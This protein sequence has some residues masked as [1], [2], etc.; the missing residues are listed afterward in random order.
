LKWFLEGNDTFTVEGEEIILSAGAVVSPQI[1]M[2]SGVG[3][4]NHLSHHGINTIKDSP[5]VGQNLADHPMVYV[6][7]KTK[8]EVDLDA[9][10]PRIQLT[11]RYTADGSDLDNDM[12]VYMMAVASDRPERGG[13]R[14]EPIGIQTNLCINLAK[15]KGE[16]KLNSNDYRDQPYLDYNYLTEEEDKRR[17]RDGVR[18]L[19]DL[20]THP[21][22]SSMIEE[23]LTPVDSDLESDRSLDSWLMKEVTTGHHISCTNKMGPTS[24]PYSVV[25]QTGK[26][27][28]VKNLRVVDASIMPECVRANINVTVM[29][30]AERIADFIKE[31]K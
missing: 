12:I 2:L 7:W 28:G 4:K 5:G 10:G 13:L 18:M 8:P 24:D 1:L 3:P 29:T 26:V 14:T 22:M 11:L 19:V 23:R 30:M 17:F 25:S 16:V 21:D 9:L 15:G 20:E 31:G 6:T 27:H